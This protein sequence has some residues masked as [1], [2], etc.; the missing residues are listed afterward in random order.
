MILSKK[1]LISKKD[2]FSV[3][4]QNGIKCVRTKTGTCITQGIFTTSHFTLRLKTWIQCG[5]SGSRG[6]T[7]G[8]GSRGRK[9]Q[10][11]GMAHPL[12]L[13]THRA[14]G[15][16]VNSGHCGQQRGLGAKQFC[17]TKDP[18]VKWLTRWQ[19]IGFP[20]YVYIVPASRLLKLKSLIRTLGSSQR[21]F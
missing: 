9:G 19:L 13:I 6:L 7:H 17:H 12:L 20:L 3:I 1:C 4:W 8:W 18:W 10:N 16:Q 15:L 2:L 14:Q 21:G 11:R 5:S